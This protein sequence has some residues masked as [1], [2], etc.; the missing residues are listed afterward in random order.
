MN[1]QFFLKKIF[2]ILFLLHL[3]SCVT[4]VSDISDDFS[5][6]KITNLAE[7]SFKDNNFER[8]GDIYM[9]LNELFPYSDDARSS[10]I[11]A[12]KSY[13]K[14]KMTYEM[15]FAINKFFNLYPNS[16]DKE[17][18]EYFLG[19]SYFEQIIDIERDQGSAFDA[20]KEFE[21]FLRKYPKSI[22]YDEVKMKNMKVINQ[23]AGQEMSI[24]RYYLS[25]GDYL[26]SI[27]RFQEVV[28]NYSKTV[29]TSE[30]LYRLVE[31]YS[32]LGI[33]NSIEKLIKKLSDDYNGSI[34]EKKA[35]DVYYT[36]FKK[37]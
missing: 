18:L 4:D 24:G 25:K 35:K 15:R 13:H 6:S 29:H 22:Y 27:K 8:S 20:T 17:T 37:V 9:K 21:K 31:V 1:I 16:K 3:C 11:K 19:I 26:A 5:I 32:I 33:E 28:K 2:L 14:A 7:E 12:V 10:L 34:W 36:S 30:A 23:L